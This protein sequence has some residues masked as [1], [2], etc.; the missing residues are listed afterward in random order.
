M[1]CDCL[2]DGGPL[3]S[4][5]QRGQVKPFFS[6]HLCS[7]SSFTRTSMSADRP[8]VLF[9]YDLL[10]LLHSCFSTSSFFFL[11]LGAFWLHV[12]ARQQ[13]QA[14]ASALVGCPPKGPWSYT[15]AT[16]PGQPLCRTHYSVRQALNFPDYN[17]S[18][19]HLLHL[20]HLANLPFHSHLQSTTTHSP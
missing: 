12:L 4:F 6:V 3:D 15:P 18:R 19:L 9:L 14:E 17:S 8:L 1:H 13:H 20:I 10:L 2:K 7:V 16:S 5:L 11:T